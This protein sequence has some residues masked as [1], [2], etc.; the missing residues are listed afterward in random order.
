MVQYHRLITI[1]LSI[2]KNTI[3]LLVFYVWHDSSL[4]KTVYH[5]REFTLKM[6]SVLVSTSQ[7]DGYVV[8]GKKSFGVLVGKG[9]IAL[10][11]E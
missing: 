8:R 3:H 2:L 6:Y 10:G 7:I 1:A 5:V 4:I 11:R 9:T